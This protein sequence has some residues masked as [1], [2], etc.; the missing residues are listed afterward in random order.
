MADIFTPSM[1]DSAAFKSFVL[2]YYHHTKPIALLQTRPLNIIIAKE[3]IMWTTVVFAGVIVYLTSRVLHFVSRLN[4][5]GH[6]PGFR[7][8]FR[9]T[10]LLGVILP[11]SY[12]NPGINWQ[13]Q[14]R[15]WDDR[16]WGENVF[17]AELDIYKRHRRVV[18]AAF[19]G[20]ISNEVVR[21]T[22][23]LYHEMMDW[24]GWSEQHTFSATSFALGIIM[25][26][27]FGMPFSWNDPEESGE[28]S[29]DKAINFA[30]RNLSTRLFAPRWAYKL[31]I[32][33][34]HEVDK[35]YSTVSTHM[36]AMVVAK[37]EHLASMDYGKEHSGGDLFTRLVAASEAEEHNQ[38][39]DDEVISNTFIFLLAGRETTAHTIS[40]ALV[41]LALHEEEQEMLATHIREVLP[42]G[43]DPNEHDI[44]L[45][46]KV[47]ACFYEAARMFPAASIVPRHTADITT[48]TFPPE[49]GREPLVLPPGVRILIDFVGMNYDPDVYPDPERYDP[50][51]W[52]NAHESDL[53]VFGLGPRACL[54]RKFATTEAVCLLT[55]FIRNW[56]VTVH[57]KDGETKEQWRQRV[58]QISL[59]GLAFGVRDVPLT[60]TK[61]STTC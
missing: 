4:S 50:S 21:E 54:G 61:R 13:W 48:L 8:V 18:G 15:A 5:I 14:W 38:L 10:S 53:N 34:L 7:C 40:A 45:L 2:R 12:F 9:P 28:M 58:M 36:H 19:A 49:D 42:D 3:V 16:L 60:F 17:S 20:S 11:T 25:R 59:V 32:K 52:Y 47:V 44:P 55:L 43:R 1:P 51:R 6:L 24:E 27:G 31:P 39:D 23:R 33:K 41:L 22:A 37:R 30:M 26:C 35:A 57:L 29:F 56:K 46:D